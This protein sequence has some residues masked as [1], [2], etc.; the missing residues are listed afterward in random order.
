MMKNRYINKY[1][2]IDVLEFV[3]DQLKNG[4]TLKDVAINYLDNY[5]TINLTYGNVLNALIR[6]HQKSFEKISNG[7]MNQMGE[8]D[9]D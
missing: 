6:Q 5:G 9:Y 3:T 4:M 8:Y 7:E 1:L 2:A